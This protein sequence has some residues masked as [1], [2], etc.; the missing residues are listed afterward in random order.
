MGQWFPCFPLTFLFG[1]Y[2]R[3]ITVSLW[4]INDL[5]C[6]YTHV[7]THTYTQTQNI[8]PYILDMALGMHE[9]A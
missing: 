8:Y 5:A 6:V 4:S 9:I 1:M 2:T 7:H 3:I